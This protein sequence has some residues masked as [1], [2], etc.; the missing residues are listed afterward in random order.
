[1]QTEKI[2]V[3]HFMEQANPVHARKFIQANELG[4]VNFEKTLFKEN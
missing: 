3:L 1:M 2:Q 4:T